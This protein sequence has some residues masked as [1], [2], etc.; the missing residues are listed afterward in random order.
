[1]LEIREFSFT[2]SKFISI[3]ERGITQDDEVGSSVSNILKHVRLEKDNALHKFSLEFDG[4]DLEKHPILVQHDEFIDAQKQVADNI[5]IAISLAR[6]NIRK[7]HEY[8]KRT[9]YIHSDNDYVELSKRV[10]P[11]KKIGV[12]CP[13]KS[14]PLFSSLILVGSLNWMFKFK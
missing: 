3:L 2:D 12:C 7:F 4:V 10:L 5:M 8:Q 14:A 13:A 9:G 11:L 6:T 1:M